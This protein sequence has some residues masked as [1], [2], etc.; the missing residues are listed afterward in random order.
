MRMRV[1]NGLL[2]FCLAISASCSS[3]QSELTAPSPSPETSE[4][5]TTSTVPPAEESTTTEVVEEFSVTDIQVSTVRLIAE[6]AFVYPFE[7]AYLE[8]GLGSGFV[9]SPDGHVLTNNHVVTGAAILTAVIGDD[10]TEYSARVVGVSECD[11]LAVVQLSTQTPTFLPIASTLPAIGTEVFAAGFPGDTDDF[12]DTTYTL[13]AGILSSINAQGESSWASVGEELEHDAK[14]RGGSSGG[15]LVAA[16]GEVIGVNYAGDDELDV[17]YAV[18]LPPKRALIDEL[19]QGS[20]VS[21]LGINGEAVLSEET[22]AGLAGIWIYGVESGS[23]ADRAGLEPG[24]LIT[25]IE[26]LPASE[27]GTME[28]YCDI[29]RTRGADAVTS[30]EVYRPSTDEFLAGQVNGEAL[31]VRSGLVDKYGSEFGA[32]TYD[33]FIVV[34]DDSG[35]IEVEVPTEWS[36]IDGAYDDEFGGPSIWASTNI[37]DFW[38]Y[39]GVPGVAIDTTRDSSQNMY[40][41]LTEIDYSQDCVDAGVEE[42]DDGIYVGYTRLWTDC[43]DDSAILVLAALPQSQRFIVR[44]EAQVVTDADLDALDRILSTFYVYEN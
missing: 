36:D 9:F 34:T 35:V 10:P 33:E 24:D 38:S 23:P 26:G 8:D 18:S 19:L 20:V 16:N 7:G 6:G 17:H 15:P 12:E 29:L 39:Y 2:L 4:A 32:G 31:A 42:Y 5:A 27:D 41:I 3:T 14:I 11:D 28:V 13:T 21:S 43:P 1:R 40:R 44:L 22:E 37:D 30:L 25:S